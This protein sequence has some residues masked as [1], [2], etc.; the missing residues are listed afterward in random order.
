MRHYRR[1]QRIR[2]TVYI[3]CLVDQ[4]HLFKFVH[5]QNP[6]LLRLADVAVIKLSLSHVVESITNSCILSFEN[7]ILFSF[8]RFPTP[9][10]NRH[11]VIGRDMI[12]PSNRPPRMTCRY[13][14]CRTCKVCRHPCRTI[15]RIDLGE[16]LPERCPSTAIRIFMV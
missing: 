11:A 1:F 14:R 12:S 2:S 6:L 3:V 10:C 13:M 16:D 4:Q 9:N 7:L 5:Y 8:P 15:T